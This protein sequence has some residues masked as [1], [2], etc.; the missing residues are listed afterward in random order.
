MPS[1]A[2]RPPQPDGTVCFAPQS[3]SDEQIQKLGTKYRARPN[4]FFP[5]ITLEGKSSRQPLRTA[6]GQNAVINLF[7]RVG[8]LEKLPGKV[9]G[10]SISHNSDLAMI[11]AHHITVDTE[12]LTE[13]PESLE[14]SIQK[15]RD[16]VASFNL[17]QSGRQ[18]FKSYDFFSNA[19]L[20]FAPRYL[21]LIKGAVDLLPKPLIRKP[22]LLPRGGKPGVPNQLQ[23]SE[24]ARP[25]WFARGRRTNNLWQ[26]FWQNFETGVSG[27][28]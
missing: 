9:L 1:H 24:S 4:R 8:H 14:A 21:E 22:L 20:K 12:K 10:L 6:G 15:Y 26:K 23:Q 13:L 16:E 11:Y 28:R 18:S 3:F 17:T 2:E 27:C 5:F 7:W 19:Y 25:S